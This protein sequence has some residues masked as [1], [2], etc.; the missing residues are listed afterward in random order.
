M[1]SVA[2][3]LFSGRPMIVF[4]TVAPGPSTGGGGG[5]G[6]RLDTQHKNH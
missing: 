6:A 5:G 2:D 1:N 4:I 3:P